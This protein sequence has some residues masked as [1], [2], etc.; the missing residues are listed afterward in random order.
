MS[1]PRFKAINTGQTDVTI[2][3]DGESS[4]TRGGRLFLQEIIETTETNKITEIPNNVPEELPETTKIPKQTAAQP[5]VGN[6][7]SRT[8]EEEEPEEE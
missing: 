5:P 8:L 2:Q 4:N 6:I 3:G 1:I 7:G